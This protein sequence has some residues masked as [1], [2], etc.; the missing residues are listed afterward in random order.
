MIPVTLK[1]LIIVTAVGDLKFPLC[2][3]GEILGMGT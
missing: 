1:C 2:Y 3:T